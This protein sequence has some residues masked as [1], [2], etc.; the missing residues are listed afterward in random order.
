M[1]SLN[2]FVTDFVPVDP[3][4]A[5]PFSQHKTVPKADIAMKRKGVRKCSW[6]ELS[7]EKLDN[8]LYFKMISLEFHDSIIIQQN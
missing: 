8:Y 5:Q 3:K 2:R 7:G 4:L 6:R 1:S